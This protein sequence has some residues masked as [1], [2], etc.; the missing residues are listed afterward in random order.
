MVLLV[1]PSGSGKT[2]LAD[3]AGLPVVALDD[4]YRA[5]TDE[6]LPRLADGTVDWDHPGSWDMAA[7]IDALE[8]LCCGEAVEV[9]AY[10]I[11]E[12][13]AVGTRTIERH[14]SC[15]VVAEGIF[16]AEL[17]AP[18]RERGLLA[19]ALLIAPNRWLTF[20]RRLAR[21]VREARKQRLFL[22]KQGWMKTRSE[23]AVIAHQV[24]LGAR[25][26]SKPDASRRLEELQQTS[27]F[28]HIPR[29]PSPS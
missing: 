22:V 12:N 19:D 3:R 4:F 17:I 21:D 14:G 13:R 6:D 25:P 15:L 16:A 26:V 10:A 7:A 27:P 18:L 8:A 5:D 1:G 29:L 2:Y 9:P 20:A 28:A 23:P 11:A 24:A